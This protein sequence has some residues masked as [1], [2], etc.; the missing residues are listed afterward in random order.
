MAFPCSLFQHKKSSH[1]HC[2]EAESSISTDA[3]EK[4]KQQQTTTHRS[5]FSS[6]PCKLSLQ[7]VH[8]I[9]SSN[10]SICTNT[11]KVASSPQH[12]C[13]NITMAPCPAKLRGPEL[14]PNT[15]APCVSKLPWLHAPPSYEGL[16]SV[17][18]PWHRAP[19]DYHGSMPAQLPG[20]QCSS[21]LS[22]R[23]AG[24]AAVRYRIVSISELK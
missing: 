17:Q 9:Q 10:C 18:T 19:P 3:A 2:S 13:L 16:N 22:W 5:E 24:A 20:E 11:N 7:S 1:P 4:Y 23:S 21:P 6:R 15:M 8:T 12:Q 14:R